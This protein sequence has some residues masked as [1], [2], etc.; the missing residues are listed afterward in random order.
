MAW[1]LA[2]NLAAR[3]TA[4]KAAY[5][6]T[7]V[8]DIGDRAHAAECSDHNPDARGIVHAIDVMTYTDEAK[9]AAVIAW[10]IGAADLEY[11]IH[12]RQIWSVTSGWQAQ[13][14]TGTN[15]H[16]DHVH[17][18]G[19][20]GSV[21]RNQATCVGYN[22]AA[23]AMS[24]AGLGG[25]MDANQANELGDVWRLLAAIAGNTG[26]TVE[27]HDGDRKQGVVVFATK[28]DIDALAAKVDAV[29][30]GV[31]PPVDLDTLAAKVADALAADVAE[32]VGRISTAIVDDL[33]ARLTPRPS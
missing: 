16:T 8:Y 30:V 1:T 2:H 26:G 20:H 13:P 24:P 5:P 29:T 14:Y 28:A 33:A 23:E 10:A 7:V 22:T 11:V 17:L 27:Y 31:A 12:D 25:D 32:L 6:G 9:A 15:P 19:R 18:S 4:I 3:S 21:G